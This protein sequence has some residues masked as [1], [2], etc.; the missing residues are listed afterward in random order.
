MYSPLSFMFCTACIATELSG[1][2]GLRS[3]L[4]I[5]ASLRPLLAV[6]ARLPKRMTLAALRVADP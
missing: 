5:S 2:D 6:G 1:S 4:T 3:A